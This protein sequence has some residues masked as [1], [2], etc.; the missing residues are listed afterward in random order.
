[1]TYIFSFNRHPLSLI[2][3]TA[4]DCGVL[5]T[6]YWPGSSQSELSVNERPERGAEPLLSDGDTPASRTMTTPA[7]P[8]SSRIINSLAGWRKSA[9]LSSDRSNK[10][11]LRKSRGRERQCEESWLDEESSESSCDTLEIVTPS[12]SDLQF[13][14][15]WNINSFV[16]KV[17]GN[18][19]QF[20]YNSDIS[21]LS[22][23]SPGK[24]QSCWPQ[25]QAIHDLSL[26][27]GDLLEPLSEVLDLPGGDEA[28]QP[29]SHLPQP[30]SLQH[31]RT[32]GVG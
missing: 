17:R 31:R 29:G 21:K 2:L 30:P 14:Y 13:K 24:V 18:Y 20:N 26:R 7:P 28:P 22:T 4:V 6:L 25:L 23:S 15:N 11:P 19:T 5:S 12:L 3:L 10:S 8:L 27:S 1:M 9:K 32:R 16:D